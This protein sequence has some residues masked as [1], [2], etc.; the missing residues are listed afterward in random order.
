MQCILKKI[1]KKKLREENQVI[2]EKLVKDE[3]SIMQK[4][5]HPKIARVLDII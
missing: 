2:L 3:V 1:N 5:S 4:V